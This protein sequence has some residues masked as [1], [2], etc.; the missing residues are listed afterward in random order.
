MS[1]I[2]VRIESIYDL[3]LAKILLDSGGFDFVYPSNNLQNMLKIQGVDQPHQVNISDLDQRVGILLK[4]KAEHV[5]KVEQAFRNQLPDSL[6]FTHNIQQ[7]SV[8]AATVSK[9]I[10]KKRIAIVDLD[11]INKG[12]V[13]NIDARVGDRLIVQIKELT[14]DVN[15]LPVCTTTISIPG[16]YCI[17]ELGSSF[18]RVSKKIQGENRQ[19]LHEMGKKVLPEGFGMIIRTSA[20]QLEQSQLETEIKKLVEKWE[21]INSEAGIA[22]ESN[23]VISGEKV[24]ELVIGFSSKQRL[25]ELI[26]AISPVV[27]NYHMFKSYSMASG[28]VLEFASNFADKLEVSEV[29]NTLYK[30]IQE[31]DYRIN[32][33]IKAEFHYLDG[34]DEEVN[35]GN[36]NE[37]EGLLV[38]KRLVENNEM[39]F[40]SFDV[41]EGDTMQV[42]F[43]TGSWSMHYKFF[44]PKG[45][46]IG[47]WLRIVGS[48]DMAY[49]GR[50]RAYDMGMHLFKDVEGNVTHHVDEHSRED[51]TTSSTI[52]KQLDNKLASVLATARES[53][54]SSEDRIL[55][56]L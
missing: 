17:L 44:N 14:T 49:R 2:L 21:N 33:H 42:C 51:L 7:D 23:R 3:G 56:E 34:T 18:V 46:K 26:H 53:L 48:L 4:G 36:I 28:F 22:D 27:T 38:S 25:D 13:F 35:L 54:Q 24:S 9:Y 12:I 39:E 37:N 1:N 47:E 6:L 15:K 31:R 11:G 10:Y 29:H 43:K 55:I 19:K 40:P 20:L 50:I 41:N 5:E 45:D 32:N 52:T 8:Y 16:N 30:M